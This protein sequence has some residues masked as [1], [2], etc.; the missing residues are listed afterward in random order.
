M[1]EFRDTI[2]AANVED[3]QSLTLK[4]DFYSTSE[5][6]DLLFHVQEHRFS[7]SE[8]K[9]L[10]NDLELDFC[11]FE[12]KFTRKHFLSECSNPNLVYD[13]DEWNKFEL[14]NPN[15]FRNMYEFWCQKLSAG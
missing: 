5:F 1:I 7:L 4:M 11:G 9:P 13:L 6:R 2:I 15:S 10:L 8:I 12:G 3:N 14:K